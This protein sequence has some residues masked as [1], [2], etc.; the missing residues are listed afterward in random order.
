MATP[1]EQ[2]TAAVTSLATGTLSQAATAT[3]LELLDSFVRAPVGTTLPLLSTILEHPDAPECLRAF[4]L[5]SLGDVIE[6]QWDAIAPAA[7]TQ[8]RG[9]CLHVLSR[10][11][12]SSPR[13][14]TEKA[15][16]LVAEVAERTYPQLWPDFFTQVQSM[17]TLGDPQTEGLMLVLKQL[18]EDCSDSDFNAKLTAARRADVL[19]GL[20][21]EVPPMLPQIYQY[22]QTKFGLLEQPPGPGRAAAAASL[23]AA[24]GM[25]RG[26]VPWMRAADLFSPRHDFSAVFAA[27]LRPAGLPQLRAAAL[28]CLRELSAVG[29]RLEAGMFLG[30]IETLPGIAGETLA[31]SAAGRDEPDGWDWRC[32]C[33]GRPP[34]VRGAVGP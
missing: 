14:Q 26:F 24:L 6:R 16:A 7:H 3:A 27:L 13:Y 11:S 34:W 30:L 9:L 22:M 2:L 15:A 18:A 25:L 5:T 19:R 8:I 21:A 1:L 17:S 10:C 12:P 23:C 4:G 32:V 31:P 20:H 29:G 28:A 33:C